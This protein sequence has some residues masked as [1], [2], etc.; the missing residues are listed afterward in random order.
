MIRRM[1]TTLPYTP[2]PP[3]VSYIVRING[4]EAEHHIT[5]AKASKL[6]ADNLAVGYPSQV[7]FQ[8]ATSVETVRDNFNRRIDGWLL[9]VHHTSGFHCQPT[10]SGAIY[11]PA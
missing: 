8:D 5:A 4:E 6:V 7:L 2:P 3:T 11:S 9:Q 1:N 10:A